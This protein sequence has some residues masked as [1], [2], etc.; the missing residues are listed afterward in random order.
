MDLLNC[1]AVGGHL[2]ADDQVE[3]NGEGKN[4]ALEDRSLDAEAADSVEE[5][6]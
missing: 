2:S 3:D 5:M 1:D 6:N 4:T